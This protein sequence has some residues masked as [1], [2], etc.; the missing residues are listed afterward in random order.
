MKS[1]C[2]GLSY[3]GWRLCRESVIEDKRYSVEE[4]KR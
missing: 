3:L 1:L 2:G 4:D